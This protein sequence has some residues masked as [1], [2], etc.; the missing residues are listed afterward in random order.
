MGSSRGFHVTEA[1]KK[2]NGDDE[3]NATVKPEN[4]RWDIPF[5]KMKAC[6]NVLVGRT[7]VWPTVGGWVG[8]W[9]CVAYSVWASYGA[10]TCCACSRCGMEGLVVFF[11]SSVLYF[12]FLSI[13]T[14]SPSLFFSLSPG[15]RL[16][17]TTMLSES[18]VLF[19]GVTSE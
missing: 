5:V 3:A 17:L 6:V 8:R 16:D 4:R 19:T 7:K 9:C 2:K 14:A 15:R 13:H 10:R 12:F 1:F 11:L 18:E